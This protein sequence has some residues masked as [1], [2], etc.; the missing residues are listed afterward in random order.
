MSIKTVLGEINS[1]DLGI[2]LGHEHL[3]IDLSR[4]RGNSDS[5]YGYDNLIIE[6]VNKSKDVGVNSIV[7]VTTIDMG[8]NV[9]DLKKISESCNINI[10]ASTGFYLEEYHPKYISELSVESISDIFIKELTSGI[11]NTG[12]KAGLIGEIAF[13]N[14]PRPGEIKV[15]KAACIAHKLTGAPI[16]THCNLGR[17][18]EKQIE[19]FESYDVDPSKVI[20]GHIDLSNDVEYMSDILSKGYNIGFDTIGKV[21]YLSDELRIKNLIDLID[22]GYN[23]QI[24]L[25]QDVSKLAYLKDEG[26]YGFTTVLKHFI[27]KLKRNGI[28]DKF[29]NNLMIDNPSRILDF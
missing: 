27:P 26:Y 8:R 18:A 17:L 21:N 22:L 11:D 4:V 20:I 16:S 14:S 15:L 3:A 13:G 1:D 24:I 23:Y 9:V 29:I 25:S 28:S 6:E 5:T 7:E 2:T 19:I 12:I 10:I